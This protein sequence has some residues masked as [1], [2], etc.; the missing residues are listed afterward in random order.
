MAREYYAGIHNQAIRQRCKEKRVYLWELA[1]K[2]NIS[3]NTLQIRMRKEQP[4]KV[5]AEWIA[6]I[7][8][9]AADRAAG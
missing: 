1:D 2:L 4:E 9:L 5:Q 8:R 7:D 6:I 3:T